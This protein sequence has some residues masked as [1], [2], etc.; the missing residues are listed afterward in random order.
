MNKKDLKHF[1]EILTERY[2]QLSQSINATREA[3][4][5]VDQDD[6]PD[7]VDLASTEA[8]QS[9]Q[10]RLRDREN[11][12]LKKIQKTLQ[13]IEDG[14]FGVCDKCGD[15]IDIKR[16]EARPVTDMCIRCKEEEER[17]EKT[18]AG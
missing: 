12:L 4:L 15:D 8:D 10:L 16:L 3:A 17:L 13:K 2:E 5:V 7:E 6:L 14:D 18:Y 11:I 9:M 1:K